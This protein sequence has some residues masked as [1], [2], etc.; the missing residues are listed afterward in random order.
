MIE[1]AAVARDEI[2]PSDALKSAAEAA[3]LR[4]EAFEIAAR[5][6]TSTADEY[7]ALMADVA[8]ILDALGGP[9]RIEV[10]TLNNRETA[11]Q[12]DPR[13]PWIEGAT[14]ALMGR[15]L[16]DNPYSDGKRRGDWMGGYRRARR[17]NSGA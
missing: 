2:A 12:D 8:R 15:S 17:E 11:P 13:D 1:A 5:L 14:A 16:A 4:P 9:V 3:G 10:A 7:F 6:L